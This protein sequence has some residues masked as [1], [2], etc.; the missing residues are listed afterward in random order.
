MGYE[1]HTQVG[2]SGYEIDLAVVHPLTWFDRAQLNVMVKPITVQKS[3]EIETD[4]VSKFLKTWVGK[5][6]VFGPKSGLRSVNLK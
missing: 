1:V 3:L 6:T 4:Y 2:A 5:F